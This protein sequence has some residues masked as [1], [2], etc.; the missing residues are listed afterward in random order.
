MKRPALLIASLALAA[1]VPHK[2]WRT[3]ANYPEG[4]VPSTEVEH[5]FVIAQ[6]AAAHR[7]YS[8]AFVEF[9]NTGEFWDKR[10]LD[11]ALR[12][13]DDAD[14]RSSH[15]AL[16]VTFIHGWKNNAREHNNNVI[17]FRTQLNQIAAQACTADPANPKP[18]E[19]ARCGVVGIYLAWSGDQVS[20]DWNTLRTLS[21]FNRRNVASHL[22]S[23]AAAPI[24]DSLR[25]I[26]HQVK[27]GEGRQSNHSVVVGHSFGGLILEYAITKQMREVGDQLRAELGKGTTAN[28]VRLPILKDLADLVVLINQ[29]APA[30][31]AVKLLA[32]YRNELQ[33]V[34]IL[35]PPRRAGCPAGDTSQDCKPLT[36]PLFLSVSSVSDTA[37]RTVLPIAE[38]ISPPKD[39]PRV[40][41]PADALPEGLRA[42]PGKIFTHAAAH[43]PELYS[44]RLLP[45]ENND[46]SPCLK[47]DKFY[48]PIHFTLPAYAR[49]NDARKDED[50]K[51]CLVRD[52]DAWNRT[53]YWIFSIPTQLVPDHSEIFTD[54]FTEFLTAFLPP[55]KEFSPTAPEPRKI[56]TLTMKSAAAQ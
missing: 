4:P 41:P 25:A 42:D 23:I 48:I 22:S 18:E 2:Q 28:D 55:L 51:Y 17:Q 29:A 5:R 19:T 12:A 21:Y 54:R 45:C 56:P 13:I 26:M 32:E 50:L 38:T 35:I 33:R 6:D 40:P 24:A 49:G 9:K 52:F 37:T 10:Q 16:V 11:E 30:A 3:D 34:N 14:R 31:E 47:K 39:H 15:H 27:N 46:C 43:T 8:F 44:H 20:R 1:C 36:R 53:P 7:L